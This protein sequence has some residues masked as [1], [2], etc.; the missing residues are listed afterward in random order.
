MSQTLYRYDCIRLIYRRY[1]LSGDS[2]IS[3][4]VLSPRTHRF[5]FC[6]KAYKICK[7]YVVVFIFPFL[8][9]VRE[10]I[11]RTQGLNQ[12]R[13]GVG[14]FSIRSH[15]LSL[16]RSV[17]LSAREQKCV[18]RK[19]IAREQ[20]LFGEK[21]SRDGGIA[22]AGA[23]GWL[24]SK[25]IWRKV[26]ATGY[27]AEAVAREQVWWRRGQKSK[28]YIRDGDRG[29]QKSKRLT[30]DGDRGGQKS[31][32]KRL[33]RDGDG[34]GQKSKRRLL[35]TGM[36]LGGGQKSKRL[37]YSRRGSRRAEKQ[38]AC[39]LATGMALAGEQESKG[40]NAKGVLAMGIAEG[41]RAKGLLA[42][43]IAEGR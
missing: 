41:R 37:A 9:E 5:L 12:T 10:F 18:G 32:P 31:K 3:I 34:R 33:T 42:T 35:A 20:K 14:R 25:R 38:E 13:H 43:G 26:L 7:K 11:K 1:F 40:R 29:G 22:E 17:A 21:Y 8:P 27:R 30:R 23:S 19:V 4:S 28:A 15:S 24:E 16:S 6:Q 36:A 39:L 2:P